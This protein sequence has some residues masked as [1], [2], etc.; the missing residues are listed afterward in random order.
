M[1][2][3]VEMQNTGDPGVRAEIVAL[4]VPVLS[5][6]PGDWPDVDAEGQALFFEV[7]T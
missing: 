6:C 2:V 3:M 5:G 4:V 7:A 1:T